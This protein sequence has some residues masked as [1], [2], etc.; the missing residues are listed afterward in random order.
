M[1]III[2]ILPIRI[3]QPHHVNPKPRMKYKVGS[4]EESIKSPPVTYI[5]IH[6]V[7]LHKK[8]NTV[9]MLVGM[10]MHLQTLCIQ[11]THDLCKVSKKIHVT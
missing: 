1:V 8:Y 4:K 6:G 2:D 11:I 7:W 10:L 3:H 9:D 5:R